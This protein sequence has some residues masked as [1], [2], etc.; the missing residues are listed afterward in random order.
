MKPLPLPVRRI[1]VPLLAAAV[2]VL[3]GC[4]SPRVSLWRGEGTLP[5]DIRQ[6][7]VVVPPG[8]D[9]GLRRP[10]IRPAAAGDVA[11]ATAKT[12]ATV[13]SAIAAGAA[14][15]REGEGFV[16]GLAGATLATSVVT[17]PAAAAIG[18][19]RALP[20][21]EARQGVAVLQDAGSRLDSGRWL[22][23][24][25]RE[26]GA[27]ETGLPW[28]RDG[29]ADGGN[30][31]LVELQPFSIRL[32][33]RSDGDF[34]VNPRLRCT[35]S[36]QVFAHRRGNPT[37]LY[38]QSFTACGDAHP[39]DEWTA[40]DGALLESEAPSVLRTLAREIATTMFPR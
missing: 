5:G 10:A 17:V 33:P 37:P 19:L 2:L 18:W 11:V 15:A 39:F 36:V 6:V 24:A 29:E 16:L 9:F 3:T 27:R 25:L 1:L 23:E 13:A 7:C 14:D 4:A 28:R 26:Q 40:H 21:E 32:D 35:A 38:E 31:L 22:A 8:A 12:T 20:E 30:D 34:T